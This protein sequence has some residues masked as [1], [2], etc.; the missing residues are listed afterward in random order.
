M[1]KN[2]DG[3]FN[4]YN[5]GGGTLTLTNGDGNVG[6][7]TTSPLNK[8]DVRSD[9]YATFGKATYNAAGWS[10][11]RLGTPYTTNH[12]A[13]CSVIESYNDHASDYNSSLRFKTSSGDNAAATER[14]RITS[15]GNVGIGTDDPTR[16]FMIYGNSSNY[17]NFSP[18]E[19]DDTSIIDNTNFGATSFKKQMM[20]RLNNRNWYWGIVNNNSSYFGLASDGGSGDNPDVHLVC[21]SSGQLNTRMIRVKDSVGIGT[22][23]AVR[24]LT[25]ETS[26]F[27][28]IRA[29]RTTSGGGCAIE[30]INGDDNEWTVGVGGTGYFGIYNGTTFGQQFIIDP[31]GNVGVGTTSPGATLHVEGVYASTAILKGAGSAATDTYN[32]IL[33]GPR[34]GT[35]TSGAVHFINGSTRTADGGASTYTIRNDSGNTR[36]GN[37][38]YNTILEGNV[39]IGTT[40]PGVKLHV[41]SS[42]SNTT[43]LAKAP[44]THHAVLSAHGT[45]Q[46][47]GRLYVGQSNTYG[48]GIEY[49]GDNSP[50]STGAGADYI[51]LYRVNNGG[52]HWTA[53]NHYDSNNWEFRNYIKHQN[54]CFYAWINTSVSQNTYIV[55]NQTRVN[56][57]SDFN[58]SNGIY[59]CPIGGVYHFS[60]GAIA[61]TTNTVYRYRIHINNSQLSDVQLRIDNTAS[62]SEYGN[63]ER[64]IILYLNAN[65]TVRIHFKPD[66][67][68][69]GDHG[70]EYTYFLGHLISVS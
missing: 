45:S 40:N 41:H 38:S 51:T 12:D 7:G 32:Y 66:N 33:N 42:A 55:F 15:A 25:I 57:G 22:T 20:M 9:N 8:S 16:Q 4:I 63:G 56:R 28:V 61:T 48:G 21:N 50:T 70:H 39:G 54:S 59:T 1:Y 30:L 49:N 13:Y 65:D 47:T 52:Y 14:M 19:A 69:A 23:G 17:F 43:I 60:W 29:K 35:T 53:K 58:T 5:T 11:I 3:D 46:G 62:G 18:T 27:D 36:V 67:N 44:D 31:N 37:A 34:P 64:S 2:G 24:P 10:G 68:S 26:S 6:I